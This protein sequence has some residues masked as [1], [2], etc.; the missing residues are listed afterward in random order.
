MP[1]PMQAI[2][3]YDRPRSL[4]E[5]AERARSGQPFD[6]SLREF[7]DEFYT[8][9]ERQEEMIAD[10]PGALGA[11]Q[12][13]YLAAVAEHLSAL[14]RLPCPGWVHGAGRF[15]HRPFF[16]GGLE[17]LKATLLVESPVAFRRRMLFVG[18]DVLDRPRRPSHETER[19]G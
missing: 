15:L 2:R 5:V 10:E 8:H 7:L 18:K 13:A 19:A 11:V 6:P 1:D 17:D 12:D 4:Y 14:S 3:R 9:P 16:A